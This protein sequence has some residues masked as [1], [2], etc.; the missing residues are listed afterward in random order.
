MLSR[1]RLSCLFSLAC[2]LSI[3]RAVRA[4]STRTRS[5]SSSSC[6]FSTS[7]LYRCTGSVDID[8][9]PASHALLFYLSQ[10]MHVL[11][12]HLFY[13]FFLYLVFLEL[14][15]L[16]QVLLSGSL[17][18]TGTKTRCSHH[19]YGGFIIYTLQLSLLSLLFNLCPFRHNQ[20]K[21]YILVSKS[22]QISNTQTME[23]CAHP[24]SDASET[25]KM[26]RSFVRLW[27]DKYTATALRHFASMAMVSKTWADLMK[28]HSGWCLLS[29]V[30]A[31]QSELTGLFENENEH[32]MGSL[33]AQVSNK[34]PYY[35]LFT[36]L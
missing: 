21:S 22:N 32:N 30:R 16:L 34:M 18:I 13:L 35:C 33:V 29:P 17:V 1:C 15:D 12:C 23:K 3:K 27:C 11:E 7:I 19:A 4:E 10:K 5:C 36:D 2:C 25:W 24:L 31:D 26:S 9:R 6:F 8:Q 20:K 28:K 14:D